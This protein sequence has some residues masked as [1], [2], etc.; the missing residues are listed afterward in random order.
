MRMLFGLVLTLLMVPKISLACAPSP[1]PVLQ[2]DFASR[3]VEDDPSR[4]KLDPKAEADAK[5]ALGPI[6]DFLRDLAREADALQEAAPADRPA[7]ADCLVG[8]MAAWADADALSDLRSDTVRLTIGSRLSAFALV[9]RVAVPETTDDVGAQAVR[10]WLARRMA[11]QAAFWEQAPDGASQ[12]NLRAWA[13]LAAAATA[14]LTDDPVLRAWATWSVV[15]VLCTAAPDGSLPQEMTR[16][17]RALHYQLHAL[18][19]LVTS[20]LLLERQGVPLV[21][22]CEG[23]LQRS[24]QF[25]LNDLGTGEATRAVTG[26]VQG[27]FDGS[28]DLEGF[29]LAWLEAYIVLTGDPDAERLAEEYRPLKYSKLGGNQTLVWR[30][31]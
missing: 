12:G 18:A 8:R 15:Y 25:A 21:P 19:P 13:A 30:G 27:F 20:V 2:L 4:S 7:L 5:A 9:A 23:A 1:D 26:T 6:D 24:A 22:R 29:Q 11:E 10:A 17:R 31:Q 28:D 14:G 16:G 3:Y